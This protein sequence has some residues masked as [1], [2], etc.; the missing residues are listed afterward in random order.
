MA[1]RGNLEDFGTTQL[2]NLVHL[3]RKTRR[4]VKLVLKRDEEFVTVTKHQAI[5]RI[6]SGVKRD[7]TFTAR[8]KY[9]SVVRPCLISLWVAT[10][11]LRFFI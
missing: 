2:L 6:K 3:A 8:E 9:T 7:G 4:P 10:W 1:L 5:I 11:S